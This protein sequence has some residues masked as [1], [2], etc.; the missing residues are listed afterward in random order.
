[1][2]QGLARFLGRHRHSRWMRRVDRGLVTLHKGYENVNHDIRTNGE[3]RTISKL[4]GAGAVKTVFDVGANRGD[5]SELAAQAFPQARVHAFEIVPETFGHLRQ[6][7]GGNARV[8]INGIGL[9]DQEGT[10]DVYFSPDRDVLATC[11]A[12][13]SESFHK[14]EPATRAVP[15]TT[16]DQYCASNGVASIDFLKVDVEGFEPQVLRGFNGMLERGLVDV[17]QFEY[18]Y[19]NIDTRFLLKDFYALLSQRN[20]TI[21]KIYPDYV[22]FRPYRHVD[23]DFYGPNYLAVNSGRPDLLRIL[24][25]R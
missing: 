4:A 13:F 16:G 15:V 25:N 21:G 24:G 5:W 12:G 20:M 6:R 14:Y 10:L 11:V 17:I 23:E 3:L 7:F 2:I 18:G 9:S 22:D 1:M 8:L 19:I